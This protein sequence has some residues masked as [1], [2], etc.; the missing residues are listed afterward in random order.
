MNIFNKRKYIYI[1]LGNKLITVDAILPITL[2]IKKQNKD[3]RIRFLTFEKKTEIEIKKNKIIYKA[4]TEVG[5]INNLGYI[6]EN[7]TSKY[8]SKFFK[9]LHIG[10]ILIKIFAT[11]TK[12]IHFGALESAYLRKIYR[13]KFLDFYYFES[14][15]W[16]HNEVMRDF[17][18]LK[19]YK[20]Q[21]E[22]L[23]KN[24]FLVG[25]SKKWP[26]LK[27]NKNLKNLKM[28]KK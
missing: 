11:R 26:A 4:I 25:F 6:N 20:K 3:I 28:M 2:A 7:N 16:G 23:N 1:L 22:P 27:I 10:Y 21:E 13:I 8:I 15:G 19:R 12:I 24:N 5:K 9:F 17:Q 18:L 14:D